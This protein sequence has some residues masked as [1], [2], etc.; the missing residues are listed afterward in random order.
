MTYTHLRGVTVRRP[1]N[2]AQQHKGTACRRAL[3]FVLSFIIYHLAFSSAAAQTSWGRTDHKGEPWVKNVSLPYDI[4]RGLQGR[5]LSLWA[6]HGRYYDQSK[7]QWRWQRPQLFTTTED[8]FTQTIVVPYLMP[9]LEDAGAV[10]FTPRER[11]WQRHE[12]IVDNDP[13]DLALLA[14]RYEESYYRNAWQQAPGRGFALHSGAYRDGENPF[15]AGTARM[16]ETTKSKN[17]ASEV[18]YQPNLP[19]AGRYAVYVSYQTVPASIDDARYT[20]WHK[21]VATE[22]RVNQQMGGSTWVYLGTF[23]FDAGMSLGNRVVVSNLSG[24]KGMV[25]TDAVRFGGGMGN[26]QRGGRVSGYP[27]CL[28]GARYYT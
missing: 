10:V 4:D 22:F 9:M 14:F 16:A 5:H 6:S 15:Q 13:T 17:R 26:I 11:D 7:G 1:L 3:L 8:L 27:R 21:G 19:E 20:V 24:H 12:V 23:D 25:T 18:S 2:N 28:E